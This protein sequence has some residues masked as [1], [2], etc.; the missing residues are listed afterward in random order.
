MLTSTL[1]T[2]DNFLPEAVVGMVHEMRKFQKPWIIRNEY[3]HTKAGR[4]NPQK[5]TGETSPKLK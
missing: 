5:V 2:V 1:K 4:T 3:S